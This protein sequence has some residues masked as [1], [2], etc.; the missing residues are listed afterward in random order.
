MKKCIF[1]IG[2]LSMSL[3]ITSCS[4][5]KEEELICGTNCLFSVENVQ[6]TIMRAE[7]FDRFAITTAHPSV[8]DQIAIGIPD[9]MAKKFEEVGK[10]VTFSAVFRENTLQPQFPDPNIDPTTIYQIDIHEIR[11]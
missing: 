10:E 5:E 9:Q 11:D 4:K 6:G 8:P 7:C 2:I 1:F 3:L